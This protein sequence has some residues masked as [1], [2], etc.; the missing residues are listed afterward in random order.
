MTV[1]QSAAQAYDY[2][3]KA[4]KIR[5]YTKL[6]KES[7]DEDTRA[8][9][10]MKLGIRGALEI[11]GKALGT[12]LTQHPYFAFHKVH[13]E[14][15]AQ[16]LNALSN[17][18][19]AREALNRAIR[20]ADTSASLTKALADYESRK[21]ALK[22]IYT[23]M[24][25]GSLILLRDRATSP[26]AAAQIK[27]SG[28]TPESLQ[29]LTDKSIYE[30]RALCCQLYM[31]SLQLLAMAQV[32]LRSTETAMLRFEQKMRVLSSSGN[33]GKI[34]AYGL[35]Q[36]REWQEFDRMESNIGSSTAVEDPVG[37]ARRQ[38]E[39]IERVTDRLGEGCEAAMSDD[40]YR[41]DRIFVRMGSL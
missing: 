4:K 13:L 22:G 10:L 38:V 23:L 39:A 9:G 37:Y 28:S 6:V 20:A 27:D 16:A 15:L 41:P 31:E 32:E 8:G 36:D 26:Q 40:A 35:Q 5:T 21:N 17:Q 7:V 14:A 30:W 34:A 19:S 3:K 25:A 29:A 1:S 33:M 18:D 2:F 12:S 11:A 24:I